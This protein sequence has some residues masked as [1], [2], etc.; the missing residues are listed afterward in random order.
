MRAAFQI[1]T[2]LFCCFSLPGFAQLGF[3]QLGSAQSGFAQQS[4]PPSPVAPAAKGATAQ[5][6]DA[7]R[8]I[9]LDVVV[10][11]KSGKPVPGLQQ[12]DFTLLDDKQPQPILSFRAM[13]ETSKADDS[14]LQAIL[15]V[16][17]VNTS[18]HSVSFERLQLQ[19]F[20]QKDDGKLSLPTSLVILTDTSQGQSV[21]TL[22]GNALVDT[23]N[24]NQSGLRSIGRSQG[25]YGGAD[26]VQISLGTLEKLTSHLATQPGRKL[27]IWISPGWPM[28]SGP[29]VELSAKDQE[30]LFQNVVSLSTE[31]REARIT[32]YSV[33]PLGM[34]ASL[35]RTFYYESFLKG[36]GS[37]NKVQ[38]GN[39]G[40]QVLAT[41]SG[42]R[43]L[44]SS[45][46]IANLIASCL[47]DAKAFYTLSFDSPPAD[48]ANEYHSLQ[49]K[50]GKP[51]LTARTRTGYYAQ[52]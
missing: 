31:L 6:R 39:L 9:T 12:Q 18:F 13:E 24:S 36:V 37:A 26:R 19:K 5:A 30:W 4:A 46:D 11:D 34:D 21:T 22:D 15:L 25:F 8:R 44:T 33:D 10:T 47:V 14:P 28:L 27:L 2:A 52:R 17:A 49:I 16:D 29:G 38:N 43:V 50:I 23:L 3:A 35:G 1:L 45:N 40:L 32:L 20:L 7:S 41:Q 48:H 51:G 42:G